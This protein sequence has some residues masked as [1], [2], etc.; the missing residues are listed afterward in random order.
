MHGER[1]VA[2]DEIASHREIERVADDEVRL[3]HR[4]RRERSSMLAA[5]REQV[6]VEVVEMIRA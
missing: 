2:I 4:L 6:V 1:D 3:V 5:A